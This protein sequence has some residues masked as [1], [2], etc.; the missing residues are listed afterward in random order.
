MHPANVKG[1]GGGEPPSQKP[2]PGF[3]QARMARPSFCEVSQ[4]SGRDR[5]ASPG[6]TDLI[7]QVS[8]SG[9]ESRGIGF[10]EADPDIDEGL[11][12]AAFEHFAVIVEP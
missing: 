4:G 1:P 6:N 12:V 2:V 9:L 5:P 8:G 3:W 11:V 10:I 7:P